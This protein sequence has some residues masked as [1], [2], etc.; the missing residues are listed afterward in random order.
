MLPL[1]VQPCSGHETLPSL[2]QN[3]MATHAHLKA[4]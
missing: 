3:I 2:F 1:T 4:L